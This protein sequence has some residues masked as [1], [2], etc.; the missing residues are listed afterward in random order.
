MWPSRPRAI[1]INVDA[2]AIP[3]YDV[4]CDCLA[5]GFDEVLALAPQP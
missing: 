4:F 5:A 2:G 3:D 1:G